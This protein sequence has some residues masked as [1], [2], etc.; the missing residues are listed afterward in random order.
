MSK[1]TTQ[2]IVLQN[3][4][5]PKLYTL[6]GCF[7]QLSV[8]FLSVLTSFPLFIHPS[9]HHAIVT[10]H[11]IARLARLKDSQLMEPECGNQFFV[12]LDRCAAFQLATKLQIFRK[13]KSVET[14]C[15]LLNYR[16]NR[17]G[18]L[19]LMHYELLLTGLVR[20]S[21]CYLENV[22]CNSWRRLKKGRNKLDEK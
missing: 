9:K 15:S 3:A 6:I 17:N 20:A 19:Y 12:A 14:Q 1:N 4:Q 2:K 10:R 18:R 8:L 11:S 13:K 5:P 22:K 16:T 7:S 21:N